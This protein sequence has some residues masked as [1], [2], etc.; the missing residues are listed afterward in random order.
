MFAF[1]KNPYIVGIILV[2]CIILFTLANSG[3]FP[4]RFLNNISPCI[5]NQET[6]LT[7]YPCYAS[8]DFFVII[9]TGIIGII[10]IG[11]L[12]FDL[13]KTHKQ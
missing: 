2:A 9:I 4:S 5:Q 8:W 6:E 1:L 11:F 10:L 13:F 7:S 12:V 3:I